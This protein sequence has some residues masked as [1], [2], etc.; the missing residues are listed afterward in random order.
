M[1]WEIIQEMESHLNKITSEKSASAPISAG[2]PQEQ[3]SGPKRGSRTVVYPTEGKTSTG[4]CLVQLSSVQPKN[5][6]DETITTAPTLG[7]ESDWSDSDDESDDEGKPTSL[8]QPQH[9]A[10]VHPFIQTLHDWKEGIQVD[11]GADWEW[12][13]IEEAVARGPH[14]T[15]NTEDA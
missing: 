5:M 15:A 9:L 12:C 14:P 1:D 6:D 4:P 11:C 13:T 8:M 2:G 7:A 10:E 3:R